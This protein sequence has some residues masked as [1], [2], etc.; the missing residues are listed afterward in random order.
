MTTL[1]ETG[2][3]TKKKSRYAVRL[4]TNASQQQ[5]Q[6][7]PGAVVLVFGWAF[8]R[9]KHVLKHAEL[10]EER[11]CATITGILEPRSVA[12]KNDAAIARFVRG[13]MEE[14]S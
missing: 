9:M 13:A 11:G 14:A 6:Q 5:Q 7:A 10:Y 8:S 1:K 3:T 12:V 2:T 4:P